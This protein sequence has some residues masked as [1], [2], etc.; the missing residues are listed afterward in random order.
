MDLNNLDSTR[1][2]ISSKNSREKSNL[3]APIPAATG[4]I[5]G[6]KVKTPNSCKQCGSEFATVGRSDG[7]YYATCSCGRRRGAPTEFTDKW[8]EA[9]AGMFG[10]PATITLRQ[11]VPPVEVRP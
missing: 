11:V 9:V 6:L 2:R 4:A 1:K 8:V 5:V 7:K 10:S 3:S